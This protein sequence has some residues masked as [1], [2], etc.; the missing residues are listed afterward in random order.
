MI[1]TIIGFSIKIEKCS[2]KVP[3]KI[4][5]MDILSKIMKVLLKI[6]VF[7]DFSLAL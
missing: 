3:C 5:L 4:I 1:L 6:L 2:K 7:I